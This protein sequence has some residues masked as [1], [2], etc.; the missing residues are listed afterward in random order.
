MELDSLL[1][2]SA[3]LMLRPVMLLATNPMPAPAT[4]QSSAAR[5]SLLGNHRSLVG[6]SQSFAGV[7]EGLAGVSQRL[8]VVSQPLAD[9]SERPANA[10]QSLAVALQF[11]VHNLKTPV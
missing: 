7:S 9:A 5:Q 6:V 8:V 1:T 4:G 3:T 10:K 11:T 2:V